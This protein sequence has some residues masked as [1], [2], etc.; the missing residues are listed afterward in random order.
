[1]RALKDG[2]AARVLNGIDG[3]RLNGTT[4]AERTLPGIVNFRFDGITGEELLFSLDLAGIAVSNGS[5]C[6]AGA[7]EPSRTLLA[8]GLTAEEAKGAV[9]F[10]FGRA[11]TAEDAERAYTVLR[12]AVR[13]LRAL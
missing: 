11:N 5:A 3:A 12:D 6:S 4:D 9:R 1:M 7:S 8:L 13:R 10:S 2:F